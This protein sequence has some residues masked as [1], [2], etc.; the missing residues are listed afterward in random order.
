MSVSSDL[1]LCMS[2]SIQDTTHIFSSIGM[3]ART[4]SEER[5]YCKSTPLVDP[6]V[7]VV[8]VE[9]PEDDELD[10]PE[11]EDEFELEPELE[12]ELEEQVPPQ[13]P[14]NMLEEKPVSFR[15]L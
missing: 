15:D 1:P 5:L 4:A 6:T 10:E 3:A 14:H 12:P 2:D 13:S 8:F 9:L 7:A 11:L